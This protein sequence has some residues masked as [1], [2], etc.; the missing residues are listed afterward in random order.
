MERPTTG[1]AI[2]SIQSYKKKIEYA[3]FSLKKNAYSFI[4]PFRG[5]EKVLFPAL[6]LSPEARCLVG[7]CH[8]LVGMLHLI[9]TLVGGLRAKSA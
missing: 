9:K 4:L 7:K 1:C 3:N 8:A 5:V 2:L 6:R